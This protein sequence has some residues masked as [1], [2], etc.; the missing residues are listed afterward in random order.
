MFLFIINEDTTCKHSNWQADRGDRK[1]SE[2][3]VVES[4]SLVV[5]TNYPNSS[6]TNECTIIHEVI[7]ASAQ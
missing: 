3:N 5:H 7:N 2:G 1:G 6:F 4:D